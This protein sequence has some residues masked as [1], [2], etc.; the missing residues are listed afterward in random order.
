MY[1]VYHAHN[2]EQ[3]L[4]KVGMCEGRTGRNRLTDYL[5]RHGL[6]RDGWSPVKH[7]YAGDRAS[8]IQ[9]EAQVHAQLRA[10]GRHH[11]HGSAQELFKTTAIRP[12]FL[13]AAT[14]KLLGIPTR[15]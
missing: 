7:Y 12:H 2:A 6:S 4:S 14:R 5:Y 10:A 8:A 1:F 11:P 3:S 9:L 13:I 15:P